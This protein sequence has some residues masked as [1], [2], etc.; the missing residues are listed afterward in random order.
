MSVMTTPQA[1]MIEGSH[2]EGRKRL[3]RRLEG[4]SKAQYVKK[5]TVQTLADARFAGTVQQ[6]LAGK[7]KVVLI[8]GQ[9]KVL[10]KT[11]DLGISNVA[12]L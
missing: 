1:T 6:R 7:T 11:L 12:P 5:K 9:I 10:D 3:R 2:I 8:A 4:T